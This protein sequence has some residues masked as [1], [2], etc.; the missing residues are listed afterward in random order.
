MFFW[1]GLSIRNK[2]RFLNISWLLMILLVGGT[3]LW[4]AKQIQYL[5]ANQTETVN[6]MRSNAELDKQI[7]LLRT[8]VYRIISLGQEQT[9]LVSATKQTIITDS[10]LLKQKLLN[11]HGQEQSKEMSVL[12]IFSKNVTTD[13]L[14]V[15][16]I[17]KVVI[18]EYWDGTKEVE[19]S[20][21]EA[22]ASWADA[23]KGQ[24]LRRGCAGG[25]RGAPDR[26]HMEG[27]A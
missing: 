9:A 10:T 8:H 25:G 6:Q 7:A 19:R 24:G 4:A 16:Y 21:E 18:G 20:G 26:I 5:L 11:L 3:G 15:R 17:F 23:A 12:L 27:V 1:R 2:F 13:S 14:L 22:V